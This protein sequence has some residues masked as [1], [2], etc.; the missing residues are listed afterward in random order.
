MIITTF[1]LHCCKS[2]PPRHST[3]LS[4]G[5][6]KYYNTRS[7]QFNYGPAPA[8]A[9]DH[10][11]LVVQPF[12]R[13]IDWAT[14]FMNWPTIPYSTDGQFLRERLDSRESKEKATAHHQSMNRKGFIDRWAPLLLQLPLLLL[15]HHRLTE[16]DSTNWACWNFWE[17]R[18]KKSIMNIYNGAPCRRIKDLRIHRRIGRCAAA[19]NAWWPSIHC[20]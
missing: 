8:K 9:D 12:V 10:R 11:S 1:A 4:D 16:M 20:R 17:I 13:S 14:I 5:S 6:T 18:S 15:R 7:V 2:F 19:L 3:S